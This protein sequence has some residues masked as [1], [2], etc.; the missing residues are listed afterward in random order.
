MSSIDVESPLLWEFVKGSEVVWLLL[1]HLRSSDKVDL[2]YIYKCSIDSDAC[3]NTADLTWQG[4]A[5]F[6]IL[7]VSHLLKDIICGIRLVVL[8][9]KERH[10]FWLRV[11]Y[12]FGGVLLVVVS[13]FTCYVSTIYNSAIATSESSRRAFRA[14]YRSKPHESIFHLC[15]LFSL[16]LPPRPENTEIIVNSVVILFITDIDE[17]LYDILIVINEDWL[18]G[19]SETNTEEKS[20]EEVVV[21]ERPS[22]ESEQAALV[23]EQNEMLREQNLL[24]MEQIEELK[25]QVQGRPQDGSVTAPPHSSNLFID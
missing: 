10:K 23:R 4:W 15:H 5:A 2:V 1:P 11:K 19:M 3:R 6:G 16:S 13:L 24:L 8:S 9:G 17:K 18:K 21:G 14:E 22:G 20:D 25:G 7:M 12:F